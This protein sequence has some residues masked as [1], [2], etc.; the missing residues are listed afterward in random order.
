M[1]VRIAL[2]ASIVGVLVILPPS[3]T[4]QSKSHGD[5]LFEEALQLEEKASS[6]RDLSKAVQKYE[7]ALTIYR[8]IKDARREGTTLYNL[9]V[10]YMDWGQYARAV[11]YYAQS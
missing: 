9:G 3:L 10:R 11:E 5:R 1:F 2:V 6:N 8:K 7:E 4:A